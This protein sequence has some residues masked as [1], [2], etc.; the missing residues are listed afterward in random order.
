MI[1][2]T[3]PKI[4]PKYATLQKKVLNKL[5]LISLQFSANKVNGKLILDD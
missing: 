1:L 5:E 3:W 4:A 2:L